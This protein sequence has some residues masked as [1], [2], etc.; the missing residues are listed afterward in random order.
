PLTEI[1]QDHWAGSVTKLSVDAY[2]KKMFLRDGNAPNVG[3]I[4]KNADLEKALTLVA[5]GGADAFY[6]G[7]IAA[8]IVAASKRLGGVMS[9]KDLASFSSE[10]VEPIQ[11]TYRGWTV[12]EI[13]PNS[14]GV[15]ALEMLNMMETIPMSSF[16]QDSPAA[17]H[18]KIEAQKL[19]YQDL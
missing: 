1:I 18:F 7:P 14:Q 5:E 17:L 10:W 13:P 12:Y 19:A 8:G 2:S 4:I 9:A 16:S 6:R 3:D 11:S 15:A